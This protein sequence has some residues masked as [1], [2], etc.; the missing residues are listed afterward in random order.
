MMIDKQD[1]FA[2]CLEDGGVAQVYVHRLPGL[3]IPASVA[4]PLMLEY[5]WS[6]PI[7]IPDLR[8]TDQGIY[9]TLSFNQTPYPTFVPWSTVVAISPKGQGVIVAWDWNVPSIVQDDVVHQPT[10]PLDKKRGLS[11]VKDTP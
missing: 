5:G 1:F 4:T 9:A 2:R 6:Q 7:Q 11:I 10:L 3:D 8:W